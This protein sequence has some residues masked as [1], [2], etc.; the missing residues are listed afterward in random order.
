M[1]FPPK[2]ST[3]VI[4]SSE[5]GAKVNYTNPKYVKYFFCCNTVVLQV[6]RRYKSLL[7]FVRVGLQTSN[8]LPQV[9]KQHIQARWK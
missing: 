8:I 1:C 9:T 3:G 6:V 2:A 4:S 5:R 7:R